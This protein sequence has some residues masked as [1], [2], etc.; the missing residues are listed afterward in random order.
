MKVF[1]F[2]MSKFYL[3]RPPR[4]IDRRTA[5][6]ID[7]ITSI[8][9]LGV[10]VAGMRLCVPKNCNCEGNFMPGPLGETTAS[11]RKD[12]DRVSDLG[13]SCQYQYGW[14]S[15]LDTDRI[16]QHL[17]C[18]LVLIFFFAFPICRRDRGRKGLRTNDPA[19][20]PK[21]EKVEYECE[22]CRN[23]NLIIYEAKIE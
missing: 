10:K 20:F 7:E 19:H 8:K 22:Q 23:E 9:E 16:Q 1:K 14:A 4:Q 21:Y 17:T 6:E 2:D 12:Q 15:G 3:D 5:H 11:N 13:G 18:Q